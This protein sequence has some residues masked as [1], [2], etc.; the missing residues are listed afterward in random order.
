MENSL[1]SEYKSTVR[2]IVHETNSIDIDEIKRIVNSHTT[3]QQEQSFRAIWDFCST[4]RDNHAAFAS[5]LS[6]QS[7]VTIE[8]LT[9]IKDLYSQILRLKDNL[10][11][12][13]GYQQLAK[14]LPDS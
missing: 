2:L 8:A 10:D 6:G 7:V 4:F 11:E 14:Y 1:L 9:Q 13:W 3:S 12:R 5:T